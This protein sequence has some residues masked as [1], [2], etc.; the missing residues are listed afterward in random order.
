MY[1]LKLLFFLFVRVVVFSCWNYS[2]LD[3]IVFCLIYLFGE[4]FLCCAVGIVLFGIRLFLLDL[5]CLGKKYCAISLEFLVFWIRL[6]SLAF[7]CFAA[8][9][10]PAVVRMCFSYMFYICFMG[11]IALGKDSCVILLE[12]SSSGFFFALELLFSGRIIVFF[13]WSYSVRDPIVLPV[14]FLF[15]GRIIVFVC[16]K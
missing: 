10:P 15:L 4:G 11:F 1:P 13:C 12:F 14:E 7:L 3:S 2:L 6:F 9:L 5:L 16:W 8:P